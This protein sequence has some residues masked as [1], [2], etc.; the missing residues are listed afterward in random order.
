MDRKNKA[1]NTRDIYLKEK[2]NKTKQKQKQNKTKQ[3]KEEKK[4]FQRYLLTII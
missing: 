1:K 3:K 2:Q 4:S